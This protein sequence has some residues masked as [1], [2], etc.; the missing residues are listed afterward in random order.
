M[1]QHQKIEKNISGLFRDIL[2]KNEFSVLKK[3]KMKLFR[4]FLIARSEKKK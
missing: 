2:S 4:G 1:T 3:S